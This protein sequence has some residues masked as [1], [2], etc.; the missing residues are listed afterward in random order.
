LTL[1]RNEING[2]QLVGSVVYKVGVEGLRVGVV[3]TMELLDTDW[4]FS[5]VKEWCLLLDFKP[6]SR[7]RLK[8]TKIFIVTA[9]HLQRTLISYWRK[10][11]GW[12]W[13]Y[14]S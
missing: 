6:P 13:V 3:L 8:L 4:L 1:L 12:Q 5:D 14:H 2:N 7:R 10:T 11:C 9:L